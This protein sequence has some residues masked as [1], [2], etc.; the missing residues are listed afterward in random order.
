MQIVACVASLFSMIL[1][2]IKMNEMPFHCWPYYDSYR[3]QRKGH[4]SCSMAA[5]AYSHFFAECVLIQAALLAISFTLVAYSFKVIN[6]CAPPPKMPV[7]TVQAPPVQ[8]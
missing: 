8:Q 2:L 1:S 5:N 3:S 6:C 4:D 7:I